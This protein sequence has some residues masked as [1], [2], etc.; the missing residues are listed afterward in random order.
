MLTPFMPQIHATIK[1]HTSPATY[2]LIQL[3]ATQLST[4]EPRQ[5]STVISEVATA[6]ADSQ[7]HHHRPSSTAEALPRICSGAGQGMQGSLAGSG[8][9]GRRGPQAAQGQENATTTAHRLVP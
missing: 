4:R 5:P 2:Q 8:L 7:K 6:A 3:K 1:M 9:N